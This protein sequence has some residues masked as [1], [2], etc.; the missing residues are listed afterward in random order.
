MFKIKYLCKLHYVSSFVRKPYYPLARLTHARAMRC[1]EIRFVLRQSSSGLTWSA[2]KPA[3]L[4][5]ARFTRAA[6]A[7]D[8]AALPQ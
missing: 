3:R 2:R 4:L 6:T 8:D 5:R 1:R 7:R